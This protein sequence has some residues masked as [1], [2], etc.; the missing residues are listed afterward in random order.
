MKMLS[1]RRQPESDPLEA[2][3]ILGVSNLSRIAE[4]RVDVLILRSFV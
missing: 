4:A 1:N 3:R 2:A